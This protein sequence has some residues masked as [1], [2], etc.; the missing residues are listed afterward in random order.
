MDFSL[1]KA[2]LFQEVSLKIYKNSLILPIY[3]PH[4]TSFPKS[5]WNI[6]EKNVETHSELSW[7]SKMELFAKI[8]IFF[9]VNCF[10]EKLHLGSTGFWIHLWGAQSFIA[11]MAK[12]SNRLNCQGKI[13]FT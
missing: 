10:C 4:E 5:I 8:I 1:I 11:L 12:L 7:T 2:S 9:A 3:F 13:F 6:P